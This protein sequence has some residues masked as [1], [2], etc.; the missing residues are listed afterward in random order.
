M[1]RSSKRT[2]CVSRMW[3]SQPRSG[4]EETPDVSLVRRVHQRLL[5]RP[6][7]DL[8]G[9]ELRDHLAGLL[10]DE[11]PLLDA[12]SLERVLADLTNAV[13][14]LGPIEPLLGDESVTE[15]MLNGG[16][17]VFVERGGAVER[18]D[19]DLD[20]AA[21]IRI[22]ERIVAPLGLRLDRSSP[23]V[24]ARLPDGSRLHAVIPPLAIDGPC[25]T[26][27]RFGVRR[28]SLDG[29]G[30]DRDVMAF[31]ECAVRSGSNIVV[32]GGTGAGKTTLLN[33]LSAFIPNNSRVVTIEETAEL[34]LCKSHVVRLEA[35]PA[36]AEGKGA[37][38]VRDLVR[39]ALRMR[40]DR[41]V[42]GEVRGPEALDMLQA[43]NT[44]HDGSLSTVHANSVHDALSRIATLVLLAG[45]G[46]PLAAV[47]AQLIA[48]VDLV[49]HV[50]RFEHGRQ[51]TAIGEPRRSAT[52]E[53][54]VERLFERRGRAMVQ[55]GRPV[56]PARGVS[57]EPGCL[58]P[59]LL[60]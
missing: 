45:V 5:N 33:A 53:A 17:A 35:R 1:R 2:G 34:R 43:L 36:N 38:S 41:L 46:L 55:V 42:V 22:V 12:A 60:T 8:G 32:S 54:V 24:D 9:P 27:R 40:P 30:L 7:P 21:I 26:I 23:M 6:V 39:T 11:A 20:A 16:N 49:V 47:H 58:D 44:G 4:V 18:V 3:L 29:F 13:V 48:A 31:L 59:V 15:I 25:V 10:Q 50:G 56:R 28:I 19:M 52:G 14:G 57:S 37:V 51:V